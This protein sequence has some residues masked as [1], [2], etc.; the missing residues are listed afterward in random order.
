[1]STEVR[2]VFFK[3]PIHIEAFKLGD[4]PPKWFIENDNCMISEN[5]SASI[6]TPEGIMNSKCGDYIIKG[7]KGEIYPCKADIFEESYCEVF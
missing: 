3:K 7:I 5:G 2:R 1:M 6:K 4:N